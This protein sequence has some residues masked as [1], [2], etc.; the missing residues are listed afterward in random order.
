MGYRLLV[1]FCVMGVALTTV[2][3]QTVDSQQIS[4]VVADATG[5]VIPNAEVTVVNTATGLTKKALSDG[6]GNYIVLD[7][8]IGLYNVK[9]SVKGFKAAEV[10][11]VKVD[12]GGK[13]SIPLVMQL[14][15]ETEVVTV[16]A[17][18]VLIH[19][20]SSEVGSVVTSE[21]A[22]NLQLNGRNYV[23]LIA[24]SPG[25]SQ[26]V[27]SAFTGLFGSYGVA[28]NGQS[29]DGM[30]PDNSNFFLDGVDNK[31][32]GGSG[33]NFVNIS[34]DALEEFRTAGSA[35]DASYGGTA[36]ATVS[37]A[38]K[39]GGRDF[40]GVAYE[41]IR[42]RA[43]Q[44]YP[45][46][47]IGS[48]AL[49]PP[50]VYNDFGWT[51]GG[52]LYIPGHFNTQ[53]DKLFFFVGQ[54]FKR[55]RNFTLTNFTVP[56]DA[57]KSG[58]LTAIGGPVIPQCGAVTTNCS[59]ANG[60]ALAQLFPHQN[61]G[62]ATSPT[63]TFPAQN[64]FNSSEYLVKVDYNLNEK[65]Q[66]S[67]HFVH[68][69]YTTP[70]TPTQA[71]VFNREVPGFTSSL[72]W[73]HTF[74]PKTAN[75]LTASYSGNRVTEDTGIAQNPYF[76]NLKG[77]TRSANNLTYANLYNVTP[78][79]PSI[80]LSGFSTLTSTALNFNNYERV[81]AAKDDFAYVI[82][83]HSLKAG[84]YMWRN[85]KNQNS[86]PAINGTF[87]FTGST[88]QSLTNLLE[89]NF[90]TYQEASA[91]QQTWTRFGQ[92]EGYVQ[93]DWTVT[94]RLVVNLG[95]RYQYMEPIFSAL[96]NGSAFYPS[97]FDPTHVATVNNA[98]IITSNPYP[99]N[100][101]VLGGNGFP[102]QAQ[103]RVALANNPAV[104]ALFHNLPAGLV[105][106]YYNTPAPRIGFSYD[107]TGKQTTVLHAGF[108]LSY[109]RVEGNYYINSV[110]NLPFISVSNLT[111]GNVD[112]IASAAPASANPTTIG[113]SRTRNLEPPR[114]KNY[115]AGIQQRISSD[116]ML[117][118]NYVGSSSANLT[119]Y[120]NINQEAAGTNQAHP[121]VS[122][123]ALRPYLGYADIFQSANG[124]ISNY[125]SLQAHILKQM[126]K[127]GTVSV[128][129]TWSK[130]LTDAYYYNYNPQDST[131]IRADYGPANY[132]TPQILVINYV[133]PLP[134]W[135]TGSEW[136]K[137]AFGR[138]QVSGIT[139][140]SSGLPINVTEPSGT[141][142]AGD[143]VTSV[144]QRPN[145]V[146]NYFA[147]AKTEKQWINPAAFA[148]PPAGTFG[149][150]E[151]FGVPGP[152]YDNWDIS[153]Q[154]TFP[155][156]E[157]LG[158]DFRA[159]LFNVANHFSAF[160]INN[161]LQNGNFGQTNQATDP[162]T[163]EFAVKI[164]F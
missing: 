67:G 82:G 125:N 98:G 64:Y 89:G 143:G 137:R 154:K 37:V 93:D 52:P 138:F 112:T 15:Q 72:Q 150:F 6:G 103:G 144:S 47:P 83:H 146:G 156:Y 35:Y 8:P 62:T 104:Q 20:T 48:T 68:D 117:E 159:E 7:I 51:L 42:N 148:A 108:G 60:R 22:T 34:P 40:H 157:H 81:Y 155:I 44:A 17:D 65:N 70:G 116:T 58:D 109:E 136:Y 49:K 113:Y 10:Q 80:S 95:V 92:I 25:V 123:N 158:L 39:N 19:T 105:D 99:Y 43:I 53:R 16:E 94:R 96:Y 128:S 24:L 13:P 1:L 84:I 18:S 91:I 46:I 31:D 100:G 54:E 135:Q 122:S 12:V 2:K 114:I 102:P 85:R 5:A 71:I 38:I 130:N 63:F 76:T 147:G 28:G 4:G 118:I 153:L 160:G 133:Y 142:T 106:T 14:G 79:I 124:G 77:I 23:Q 111:T 141:N 86:I 139:R 9:A 73:T 140:F 75:T 27:A 131:N 121:G 69:Y 164:H 3:A 115:S 163:A 90:S 145:Q 45:F 74:N 36:G 134:F 162:R 41:F 30:R 56:T 66:I 87:G 129:Y 33:N 11:G 101:L 152:R 26:T 127:G 78:D 120:Q 110:Q 149:T 151:A 119:Y 32:N 29:V 50:F 161:T 59:T 107:L 55:L 126:R 88:V 21:Q 132:N 97:Y 61:G 57:E